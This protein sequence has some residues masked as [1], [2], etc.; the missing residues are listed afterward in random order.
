MKIYKCIFLSK[1][2]DK[3]INLKEYYIVLC[4]NIYVIFYI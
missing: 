3:I 4:F 2:I 1:I